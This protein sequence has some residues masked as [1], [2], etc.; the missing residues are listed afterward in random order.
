[1]A[2]VCSQKILALW[3][4][5][6]ANNAW[7][8]VSG[9]G[10]RKL[11]TT[12]TTN[13]L[14]AAARAK[15]DDSVVDLVDLRRGEIH[16]ITELYVWGPGQLPSGTEVTKSITECIYAW[17]ARYL[18]E[19][20]HIVVRI[21]LVKDAN[22]SQTE[23]DAAQDR[24]TKGI[25]EKWGYHFACC[26]E[27]GATRASD[28][29]KPCELTFE[30]QWVSSGAHHVVAVHR[31]PARS[32]MLNWYHD[33]SGDVAAHEFGHMLGNADEYADPQCP[34]RSPVNTGTV[35]DNLGPVVQR[36]VDP[37][38]QALGQVAVPV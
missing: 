15:E 9:L 27:V 12:N 32:N 4:I 22:V 24:W 2:Y 20:T 19:G 25:Q 8:W 36:L 35:M 11:D 5:N 30:V 38:C 33:D 17:T 14:L 3:A 18:Q 28:C 6:E 37:F 34:N 16:Y 7:V 26:A 31:G 23:L 1:M 13:L 10:W 21:Q 29:S